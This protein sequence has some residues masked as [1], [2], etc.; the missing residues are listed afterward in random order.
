MSGDFSI[1]VGTVGIGFSGVWCSQDGGETWFI[2]KGIMDEL[3]CC[4]LASDPHHPEVI[5]AGLYNGIYHSDDGGA[6]FHRIESGVNAFGVWSVAVDLTN[7]DV[8]FVGCRPGAVFRSKNGGGTWDKL[9]VDFVSEGFFGGPTRVLAMVVDPEDPRTV[10]AGVEADGIRRSRDGG[11]TWTRIG[12]DTA[13]DIHGISLSPG[14]PGAVFVSTDADA[15]VSI[16][17]GESWTAIGVPDRFA[18]LLSCRQI[19]VK[20][21]DPDV[22]YLALGDN[23]Y[24]KAIG[25]VARSG[26]RGKTWELLSMPVG[27]NSPIWNLA[28]H[29]ANPNR[30]VCSS[31]FGQVFVSEDAGDSWRKIPREFSEIRALAWVPH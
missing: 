2:P 24:T 6:N 20:P 11:D 23:D 4:A 12:A 5:F 1:F 9:P 22:V 17:L 30:L 3:D 7:S 26:D 21:D 29:P 25:A 16:D 19:A 10:W 15:F 8:I 28:V 14:S 27:P 31:H 13:P 18:P